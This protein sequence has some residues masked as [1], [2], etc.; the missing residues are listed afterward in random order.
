[1]L[2]KKKRRRKLTLELVMMTLVSLIAGVLMANLMEDIGLELM[3]RKFENEDYLEHQTQDCLDRLQVF[4]ET[5]QVTAQNIELLASWAQ[6]EKNVYVVF[7]QDV[8]ALFSSNLIL[9]TEEAEIPL[10]GSALPFYDVT[11]S[12]GTVIKADL[13]CYMDPTLFYLVDIT[14]F[15][16]SG[17]VFVMLLFLL[18]HQKIRYI[19]R[20]HQELKILGSGNLEYTVTIR[21]NDEITGLAEGIENLKNGI[22]DQQLMKDEAEKANVELVTAMSHDLR[23]P[24]TSLIGYLEL[25]TM[26]RY[27]DEAQMQKYLEHCRDKAFQLKRMSDRLFEYFL[28]Y[29]KRDYQYQFRTFSCENLL[30]D[31]CNSQFFDWQEQGGTL[32]CQIAELPGS[33][34]VDSEYLQRV[35]D[36]LLSNLK[37]YGD[38]Q[39][40]L[41]IT[42]FEKQHTLYIRIQ[43]HI[44]P[45]NSLKESTQI[46]LRT[47]QKILTE[48]RGN[49]RWFQEADYFTVELSFPLQK[50]S[51]SFHAQSKNGEQ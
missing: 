51:G 34:Q 7:Y 33:I 42:A 27:E 38:L 19:N 6:K 20:L 46:G 3:M 36:N 28:V 41:K 10:N 37:K 5:N 12:D 31:L 22:L 4:I 13:D 30:E 39:E 25:L 14:S 17:M 47:C 23:T 44:K 29:G 49:F 9:S 18:I 21:G 43:N 48:H 8:Q 16:I 45:M 50:A 11:L 15:M 1:M 24:L 2:T 26:Q 32:D 40:P 35:I